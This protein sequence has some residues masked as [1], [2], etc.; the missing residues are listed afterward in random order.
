MQW[1]QYEDGY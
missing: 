1:D